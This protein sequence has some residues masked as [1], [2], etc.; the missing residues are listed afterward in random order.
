MGEGEAVDHEVHLE[1][2]LGLL[3][4]CEV[5]K[6]NELYVGNIDF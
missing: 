2:E 1:L 5:I 6:R 3:N 4:I